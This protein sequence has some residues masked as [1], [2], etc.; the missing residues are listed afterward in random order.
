MQMSIVAS[1][2]WPRG[3][4]SAFS[5]HAKLCASSVRAKWRARDERNSRT[6]P[7]F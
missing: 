1:L 5:N 7:K 3:S 6:G 2:A 4:G